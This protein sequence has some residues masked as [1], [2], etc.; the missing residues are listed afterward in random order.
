MCR[1]FYLFSLYSLIFTSNVLGMTDQNPSQIIIFEEYRITDFQARWALA[2]I[3]AYDDRT[4]NKSLREY[5]ILLNEKPDNLLIRLEMARVLVRKGDSKEALQLIENLVVPMD[6]PDIIIALADLEAGLGHAARCRDLYIASIRRSDHPEKVRLRFADQMKTWGDFYKA[7]SIYREYLEKNPTDRKILL[8]LAALMRSTERYQESAGIYQQLLFTSPAS[9]DSLLEYAKLKYEEKQYDAAISLIERLLDLNA[10]QPEGL[11]LKA[12]ILLHQQQYEAAFRLYTKL[13]ET[14][15]WQ[16]TGLI[17][18]GK[19][20]ME[21]GNDRLAHICFSKAVESFPDKPEARFYADRIDTVS[22]NTFVENLLQD[23]NNSAI[24]LAKWAKM[25][26]EQGYTKISIN[27]Y[28]ASLDRDPLC[29]PSQIGL[30]EMLAIDHQYDRAEHLFKIL[31]RQF[32]GNRKILIGWARTLAW[33]KKYNEAID[34]YNQIH[35]IALSDPIP[36]IEKARTAVWAKKMDL[37]LKVY[38]ALLTPPVDQSLARSLAPVAEA[39]GNTDLIAAVHSL[40]DSAKKGFV[41]QGVEAFKERQK[42]L[43][44]VLSAKTNRQIDILL[45][46]YYPSFALQKAVYL[47]KEGKRLFWNNRFIHALNVYEA[48]L[49]FVPGNEEAIFDYAQIECA[50]GL[51]NREKKTYQHLLNTNQLHSLATRAMDRVKIRS[52]PSFRLGQFYWAERGRDGLTE[53]DRYRS[54]LEL[55]VPIDCRF[56]FKIGGHHWIEHPSYTDRY[57]RASGFSLNVG[58]TL[59]PYIKGAAEWTRKQYEDHELKHTDTGYAHVSF[60]LQDYV[61]IGLGYDK[62]DEIYNYFGIMQK[63]QSDSWW[64]SIESNI[65]RHLSVQGMAKY[66]NYSDD[67]EGR[68]YKL[69]VDY[70]FTDHPKIFK[71]ALTGEYRTTT[72]SEI[73]HYRDDRL[74]DITHPYWTPKD[75]YAGDIT[76]KWYHDLSRFLFCGSQSHFY[77]L[78]LSVA[79]DTEH[80]PSAEF[81]GEWHYDFLNHWT[82]S[83]KGMIHC[84]RLWDAEGI[85]ADIQYRF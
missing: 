14:N 66:L 15:Y 62:T 70:S 10:D 52:N 28:E 67:N 11:L 22:S 17:G 68:H 54:N 85:W 77:D 1:I 80:N 2:R 42:N 61:V 78:S 46:Q 81:R 76:V 64:A 30:A 4:L 40:T 6:D 43:R 75:Y 12:K 69:G 84:S 29:F 8:K 59:N 36:Q 60:N 63:T 23:Q 21:Q 82:V 73:Y 37:A 24:T 48:L 74:V 27:C 38:G 65:T 13:S 83:L 9:T 79:T 39:S 16:V 35:N 47:E 26:A 57:Y 34:I 44:Q 41:F 45:I 32:P 50:L 53:I 18:Q 71:V 55:D 19:V 56:H 3:L 31:D 25:Y 5:R 72:H 33:D 49:D 58:G 20:Y 51:C 7:E